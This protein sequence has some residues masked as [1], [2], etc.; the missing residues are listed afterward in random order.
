MNA[1]RKGSQMLLRLAKQ[2]KLLARCEHSNAVAGENELRD[3]L[4]ELGKIQKSYDRAFADSIENS[5]VVM[6]DYARSVSEIQNRKKTLDVQYEQASLSAEETRKKLNEKFI[7]QRAMEIYAD[8]IE[9]RFERR[10]ELEESRMID[11]AYVAGINQSKG[12]Q[13]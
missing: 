10:I 4:D 6:D 5:G 12:L 3:E 13:V 8:K 7:A 2:E 1:K 9:K 11:D